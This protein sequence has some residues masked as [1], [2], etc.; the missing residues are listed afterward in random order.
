MAQWWRVLLIFH[1]IWIQFSTHVSSFTLCVTPD[2]GDPVP[3]GLCGHL[4]AYN[5][6]NLM[7]KNKPCKEEGISET[8]REAYRQ[9]ENYLT[10]KN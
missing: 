6:H 3:V 7:H 4:H 1:R 8:N 5:A 2:P 9:T 10:L